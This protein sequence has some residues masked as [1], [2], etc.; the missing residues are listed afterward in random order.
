MAGKQN[1]SH[2]SQFIQLTNTHLLGLEV[3]LR[4]LVWRIGWHSYPR[5]W[6]SNQVKGF[7]KDLQ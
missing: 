2:R 5:N 6:W 1:C 3:N 7:V 4:S